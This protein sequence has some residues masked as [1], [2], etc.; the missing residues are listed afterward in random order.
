MFLKAK[1]SVNKSHE[2]PAHLLFVDT[3]NPFTASSN[4]PL[5]FNSLAEKFIHKQTRTIRLERILP[6]E[7]FKLKRNVRFH[8]TKRIAILMGS[9]SGCELKH[10]L[11]LVPTEVLSIL[12]SNLFLDLRTLRTLRLS[13][14]LAHPSLCPFITPLNLP[15]KLPPSPKITQEEGKGSGSSDPQKPCIYRQTRRAMAAT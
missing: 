11:L 4:F 13:R 12:T 6:A 7:T 8:R 1:H 14:P 3:T 9:P 10:S 15:T 5:P 2:E